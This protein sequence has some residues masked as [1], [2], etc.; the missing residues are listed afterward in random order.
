MTKLFFSLCLLLAT[1]IGLAFTPGAALADD[2]VIVDHGGYLAYERGCASV[3]GKT[4]SG[5]A[6]IDTDGDGATDSYTADKN[7]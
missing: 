3:D 1:A 4:G 5:S 7:G 2:C 6:Y